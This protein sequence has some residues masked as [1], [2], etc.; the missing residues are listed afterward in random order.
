VVRGSRAATLSGE[1]R[2]NQ[3]EVCND[4]DNNN[5]KVPPRKPQLNVVLYKRNIIIINLKVYMSV[6]KITSFYNKSF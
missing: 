2:F 3:P 4:Y 5:I 1:D 6:T